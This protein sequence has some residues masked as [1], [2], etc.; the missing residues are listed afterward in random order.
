MRVGLLSPKDV[1][2]TAVIKLD[3]LKAHT[4]TYSLADYEKYSFQLYPL[5]N[6]QVGH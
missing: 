5:D 6:L 1:T 4:G 2:L 3:K